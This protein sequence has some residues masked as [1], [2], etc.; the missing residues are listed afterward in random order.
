[1]E[2]MK[3]EPD[4]FDESSI[5]DII[6]DV[7][8]RIDDTVEEAKETVEEF[9]EEVEENAE[10]IAKQVQEI[11]EEAVETVAEPVE[12]VVETV[13]QHIAEP[14]DDI[15]KALMDI[16]EEDEEPVEEPVEEV[17]E[18]EAPAEEPAEEPAAEQPQEEPVEVIVEEEPVNP[19][20]HI[21]ERKAGKIIQ[22]IQAMIK[23]IGPCNTITLR[24]S[25]S[26]DNAK[27][28]EIYKLIATSL[29]YA[30]TGPN[31]NGEIFMTRECENG[32]EKLGNEILT[33]ADTI[34]AYNG[35]YRG[36]RV[37]D[38]K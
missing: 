7:M 37:M 3:E 36:W 25:A 9:T 26:F 28:L 4:E 14:V 22:Q 1:M 27:N 31:E 17:A 34:S 21:S 23:A 15:E 16:V 20:P 38:R 6:N 19:F 12:E 29:G 11:S 24:H 30:V 32:L 33:L 10:D 2:S 5:D 13:E 35:N 8:D 18:P